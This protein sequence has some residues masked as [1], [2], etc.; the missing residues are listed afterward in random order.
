M[1]TTI[2]DF[3]N[4]QAP[5]PMCK[6]NCDEDT[7]CILCDGCTNWFHLHCTKLSKTKFSHLQGDIT[8]LCDLCKTNSNCSTCRAAISVTSPSIYCVNC[9]KYFCR[10]CKFLS[11]RELN[12][13]S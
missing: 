13:K 10:K 11:C 2:V 7:D 1:A 8:Y 12:I 6:Y 5:C 4:S 9:I 3:K